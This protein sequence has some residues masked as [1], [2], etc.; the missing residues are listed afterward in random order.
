MPD[1]LEK[2]EWVRWEDGLLQPYPKDHQF[3]PGRQYYLRSS[4][5][6][7]D[8]IKRIEHD[9]YLYRGPSSE[10]I[11]RNP[12]LIYEIPP[13]D[14]ESADAITGET[15]AVMMAGGSGTEMF[16]QKKGNAREVSIIE[17]PNVGVEPLEQQK[18]GNAHQDISAAVPPGQFNC[19][20]RSSRVYVTNF[21]PCQI[22]SQPY[23]SPYAHVYPTHAICNHCR[24]SV[25]YTVYVPG[26]GTI[27]W[28]TGG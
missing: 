1:S 3:E 4:W 12:R 22:Y 5:L 24:T 18:E 9:L 28:T 10:A 7:D 11:F 13:E 25:P 8:D 15:D 6:G 27:T 2:L 23:I 26:M 16:L 21:V 19:V 17:T 20:C 14:E